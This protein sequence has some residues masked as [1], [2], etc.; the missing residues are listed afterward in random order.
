VVG[1][2]TAKAGAERLRKC[3]RGPYVMAVS[4]P[5]AEQLQLQ[6]AGELAP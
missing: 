3:A 5:P 4:L 6:E 1:F 2:Q